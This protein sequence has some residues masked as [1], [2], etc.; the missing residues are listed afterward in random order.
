MQAE[1]PEQRFRTLLA[2]IMAITGV[3]LANTA[4]KPVFEP[5]VCIIG[6]I[7]IS[8]FCLAFKILYLWPLKQLNLSSRLINRALQLFLEK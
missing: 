7:K 2:N 1:C 8:A 6:N 4:K 3:F 5:S